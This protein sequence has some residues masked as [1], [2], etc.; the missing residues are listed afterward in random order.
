MH[1]HLVPIKTFEC[2]ITWSLSETSS[3]WSPSPYD[4]FWMHD[5]LV[6]IKNFECMITWSLS[7]FVSAWSPSPHHYFWMHDHLVLSMMKNAVSPSPPLYTPLFV[8]VHVTLIM[9][10]IPDVNITVIWK[11]QFFCS[12]VWMS[13]EIHTLFSPQAWVY[14]NPKPYPMYNLIL[15]AH[16]M[17]PNIQLTITLNEPSLWM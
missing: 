5:H 7:F 11:F 3:A 6:P 4:F 1:D 16:R 2:M 13:P 9:V 10:Y 15:F 8:A 14:P 17:H 12:K